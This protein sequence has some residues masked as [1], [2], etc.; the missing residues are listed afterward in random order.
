MFGK[1]VRDCRIVGGTFEKGAILSE[2]I[3]KKGFGLLVVGDMEKL[4]WLFA[5]TSRIILTA[6]LMDRCQTVVF[7]RPALLFSR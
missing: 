3:Q 1:V 6:W 5:I 4:K 2:G 7:S